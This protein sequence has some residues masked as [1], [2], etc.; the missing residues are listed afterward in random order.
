MFKHLLVPTDG[1]ALSQATVSRAAAFAKEA[2]ARITLF[3]AKPEAPA[4]YEGV[5]TIS[6]P[7]LSQT[8]HER[9]DGA[10]QE[11]LDAAEPLLREAGVPCQRAVRVGNKPWALII[12]AAQAQGCDLI[13]MASHGRRGLDALLLGSETQKV[14]T[15]S[16]IPVLVYR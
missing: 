8:L 3:Y 4:A 7:H 14:L 6:D 5:G 11:I 15:H 16:K 2:G 9:L 10:A 13:F 12:E 1:S